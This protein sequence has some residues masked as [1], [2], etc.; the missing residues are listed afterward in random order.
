MNDRVSE[1]QKLREDIIRTEGKAKESSIKEKDATANQSKVERDLQSLK[2]ESQVYINKEL[3]FH[4][5]LGR[6]R[7]KSF[8]I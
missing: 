3:I 5:L 2:R 7:K 1:I 4:Q 6:I 8:E